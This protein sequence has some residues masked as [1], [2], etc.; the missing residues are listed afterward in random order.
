MISGKYKDSWWLVACVVAFVAVAWVSTCSVPWKP[1]YEAR[2]EFRVRNFRKNVE[3]CDTVMRNMDVM[4]SNGLCRYLETLPVD[5]GLQR[6]LRYDNTEKITLC[7][8]GEDSAA[9]ACYAA[10]LYADACDTLQR[11]G[12]TLFARVSEVLRE[13]GATETLAEVEIDLAG[14]ARYMDLLNG[15]EVPQAHRTPS[16]ALVLLLSL[17]AGLLFSF[18]VCVLKV[19]RKNEEGR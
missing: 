4:G 16:R 2:Y 9:T 17:A 15:A 7:V 1:V 18:A 14:H 12:D 8:R 10:A 19:R 3:S 5:D 11:F 6:K 13:Y